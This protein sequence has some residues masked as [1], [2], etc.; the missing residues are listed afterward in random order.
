MTAFRLNLA[1]EQVADHVRAEQQRVGQQ[2]DA[3]RALAAIT[4]PAAFRWPQVIANATIY[5]ARCGKRTAFASE[6]DALAYEAGYRDPHAEHAPGTPAAQGAADAR[7]DDE[8]AYFRGQ[9]DA[10]E[11]YADRWAQ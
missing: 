11:R 5:R 4:H 9:D 7:A 2:S 1:L 6:A 8:H 10:A 3:E